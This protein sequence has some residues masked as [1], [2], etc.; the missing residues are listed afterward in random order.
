MRK[1]AHG[2][3]TENEPAGSPRISVAMSVYNGERFLVPAIESILAQTFEDFEL[4]AL[5]DGSTD[6]TPDILRDYAR[7]DA[8]VRPIIRENRGLIASLNQMVPK[9][10]RPSSP[11]WTPMTSACPNA[12]NDNM[13]S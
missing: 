6:A 12:L 4:L 8:R 2:I 13:P 1:G 11:A 3:A 5:D 10:A 9:P 7:R